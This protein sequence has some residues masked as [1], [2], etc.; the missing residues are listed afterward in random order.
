MERIS[1]LWL[2]ASVFDGRKCL[3]LVYD[4]NFYATQVSDRLQGPPGII[5]GSL[6]IWSYNA[7]WITFEIGG[8]ARVIRIWMNRIN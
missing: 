4:G 8:V 7:Y 2:I 5:S 6:C 3:R 1:F